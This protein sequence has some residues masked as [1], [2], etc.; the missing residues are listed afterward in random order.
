MISPTCTGQDGHP[1]Q[2]L[3]SA[4]Q[5]GEALLDLMGSVSDLRHPKGQ[6]VPNHQRLPKVSFHDWP[7]RSP[8]M[9]FLESWLKVVNA[10][11]KAHQDEDGDHQIHR[12]E[13]IQ[14]VGHGCQRKGEKACAVGAPKNHLY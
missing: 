9:G 6:V 5:P 4:A 2:G 14:E 10:S 1:C 8:L 7:L 11:S 12:H 13:P 3:W